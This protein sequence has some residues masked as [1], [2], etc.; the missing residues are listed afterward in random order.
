M[1]CY[2]YSKY[3]FTTKKQSKQYF[4]ATPSIMKDGF[5][6]AKY[7]KDSVK[8][9]IFY[10]PKTPLEF[11]SG[12]TYQWIGSLYR[13]S[14]C[15][16]PEYSAL[17]PADND[18]ALTPSAVGIGTWAS[19]KGY[20]YLPI[21]GNAV[22]G[23]IIADTHYCSNV[24]HGYYA[25]F[26]PAMSETWFGNNVEHYDDA[27]PVLNSVGAYAI[28]Y[29]GYTLNNVTSR[30]KKYQSGTYSNEGTTKGAY[31]WNKC[32][33][34]DFKKDVDL[35]TITHIHMRVTSNLSYS[36]IVR[37]FYEN[38][39][40][41]FIQHN[42][43]RYKYPIQ[44]E[45]TY[46]DITKLALLAYSERGYG[47]GNSYNFRLVK[48]NGNTHEFVTTIYSQYQWADPSGTI[49]EGDQHKYCIGN[50]GIYTQFANVLTQQANFK[51]IDYV[52]HMYDYNTANNWAL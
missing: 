30:A 5:L 15:E 6:C 24:T 26:S 31:I 9:E 16:D 49:S 8:N 17:V 44:S 10:P 23:K 34:V 36:E 37:A 18:F 32:K 28:N 11:D 51:I 48:S 43:L 46:H 50:L 20:K 45:S 19:G 22:G 12:N 42:V 21:T 4:Y 14:L 25:F 40:P 52:T 39:Y 33:V 7:F 29:E 47:T 2:I 1:R 3:P 13:R 41:Q 38:L 27:F 35:S